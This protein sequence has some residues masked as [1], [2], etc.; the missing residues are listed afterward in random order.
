MMSQVTPVEEG[1][2]AEHCLKIWQ[3]PEIIE[4]FENLE[5]S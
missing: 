2:L 1:R 3:A 4:H 5:G